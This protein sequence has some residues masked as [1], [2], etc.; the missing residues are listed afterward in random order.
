MT[1]TLTT[2]TLSAMMLLAISPIAA[3]AQDAAAPLAMT[4]ARV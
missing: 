4:A 3:R 1:K 2:V